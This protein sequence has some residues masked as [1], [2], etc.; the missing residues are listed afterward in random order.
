MENLKGFVKFGFVLYAVLSGFS[1]FASASITPFCVAVHNGPSLYG[2]EN[3]LGN[4]KYSAENVPYEY[5]KGILFISKEEGK[6]TVVVALRGGK[7]KAQDVKIEGNTLTFNLKLDGPIVSVSI[8]AEGDR[9]SGKASSE[10]GIF[11][12]TGERR[13]DPE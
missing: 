9:I 7:R 13:L 11:Q 2:E 12:L 4:W 10:D 5:A 3:L 8:T 1:S 6:L